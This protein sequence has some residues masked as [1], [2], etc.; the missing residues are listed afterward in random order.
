MQRRSN[1]VESRVEKAKVTKK[2]GGFGQL[3]E[4]ETP[5]TLESISRRRRRLVWGGRWHGQ[6]VKEEERSG[7]GEV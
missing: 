5:K 3:L 7:C 6:S 1:Q 2:T 4:S